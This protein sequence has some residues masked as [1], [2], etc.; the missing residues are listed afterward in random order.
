MATNKHQMWIKENQDST[1]IEP[2]IINENHNNSGDEDVDHGFSIDEL[3]QQLIDDAERQISKIRDEAQRQIDDVQ[4]KLTQ[5]ITELD[6][7]IDNDPQQLVVDKMDAHYT[8]C[9]DHVGGLCHCDKMMDVQRLLC[10]LMNIKCDTNTNTKIGTQAKSNKHEN[11]VKSVLIQ[12]GCIEVHLQKQ[13]KQDQTTIDRI[14]NEYI[15]LSHAH[16]NRFRHIVRNIDK[17][18]NIKLYQDIGINKPGL[19]FIHQPLGSQSPPD[20]VL[21]NVLPDGKTKILALE[22]KS[23]SNIMWNDSLPKNNYAYLATDTKK[24]KT[25]MFTG[26]RECMIRLV[27]KDILDDLYQIDTHTY[28]LREQYKYLLKDPHNRMGMGSFPRSS[29]SSKNIP[30][31]LREQLF[32]Y[33]YKKFSTFI[34][35]NV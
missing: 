15:V 30:I 9:L 7:K 1:N 25:S 16:S 24:Q 10:D 4:R 17:D 13:K 20:F 19:Y 14:R 35:I 23:G 5:K 33:A 2:I 22:C 34:N 8:H 18:D 3:K 32:R 21:L 6:E 31:D 27:G 28:M 11:C 26:D 29:F 12:H